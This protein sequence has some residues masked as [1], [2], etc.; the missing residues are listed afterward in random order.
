M[1]TYITEP[2]DWNP[3]W[4]NFQPKELSC[5]HCGELYINSDLMDLLQEARKVLGPL[6]ITSGYRCSF[7]NSATSKTG[8]GGPHTTG[9]AVDISVKDSQHRKQ[10]IDYFAPE[11]TGLGIA[12]SFI[13]IDLLYEEDGPQFE[14]RPN[15]WVY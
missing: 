7:H 2:G 9:R 6:S 12:K 13:H 8:P 11:V 4:E 1:S 5:S 10:L 3:D 15:S 14:I